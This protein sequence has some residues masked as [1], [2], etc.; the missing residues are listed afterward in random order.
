MT[1]EGTR[2]HRETILQAHMILPVAFCSPHVVCC[3]SSAF[4]ERKTEKKHVKKL[5]LW[6]QMDMDGLVSKLLLLQRTLYFRIDGHALPDRQHSRNVWYGWVTNYGRL[7]HK[8]LPAAKRGHATRT[9]MVLPTAAAVWQGDSV[10]LSACC[11]LYVI[12]GH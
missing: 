3:L 7:R 6:T 5:P 10:V 8:Q 4:F 12:C 2:R 11:L 1:T 9:Q